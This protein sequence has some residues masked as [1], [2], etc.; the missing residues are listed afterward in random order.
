M[1]AENLF[2]ER[3][4]ECPKID[5]RD[6]TI[7]VID[8]DEDQNLIVSLTLERVGYKVERAFSAVEAMNVLSKKYV[9]VVISD[10][11]M[12]EASGLDLVKQLRT[13]TGVPRADYLPFIMLTACSR[14]ME[15]VSL[16]F[17]ADM[18]CEKS[19][20]NTFLLDQIEFLLS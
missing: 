15:F 7:L 12:P 13:S 17:G 1:L 4:I 10:L 16:E 20:L 2:P 19:H 11:W 18:F 14:D 6:H 5:P 9:D 3:H 8:D